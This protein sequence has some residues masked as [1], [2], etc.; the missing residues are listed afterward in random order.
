[1]T[2]KHPNNEEE[3]EVRQDNGRHEILLAIIE[4]SSR[5]VAYILI[6]LFATIALFSLKDVIRKA[7]FGDFEIEIQRIAQSAEVTKELTSLSKLSDDQLQLFLIIGKKREHIDYNGPEANKENLEALD[8]A[9]LLTITES[10]EKN[11]RYGWRITENGH[12]LHNI[13]FNLIVSEIRRSST[14][15]GSGALLIRGDVGHQGLAAL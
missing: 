10:D 2:S 6:G 5:P 15:P 3:V 8:T 7:K 11:R 9:G 14:K 13:I 12:K 1:M 4:H